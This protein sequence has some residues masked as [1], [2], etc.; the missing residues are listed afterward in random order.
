M[1]AILNGCPERVEKDIIV[2]AITERMRIYQRRKG[3]EM[4][5][6]QRAGTVRNKREKEK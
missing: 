2:L 1:K 6:E 5:N 3:V 4:L